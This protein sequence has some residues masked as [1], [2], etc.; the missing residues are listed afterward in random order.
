MTGPENVPPTR[1]ETP[2]SN[3]GEGGRDP[4]H[5]VVLPVLIL[6]GFALAFVVG[7]LIE[8]HL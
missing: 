7:G 8:P 3:G 6:V 1:P 2:S 4:W 5:D